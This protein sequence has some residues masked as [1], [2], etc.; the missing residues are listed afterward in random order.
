MKSNPHSRLR[1]AVLARGL[2]SASLAVAGHAAIAQS[3]P[4]RP[5]RLIV[6]QQAGASTDSVARLIALRLGER[7][8]QPFIVENKPGGA[9]RVAMD[10]AIR[11]QPDGQVFA[12]ANA[13]SATFPLVLADYPFIPG[14]DFAPVTMLG[15]APS[16]LAVRSTLP[17]RSVAE[18]VRYARTHGDRIVLGHGG[19]GSNPHISAVALARSIGIRPVELAYK[20]NAPTAVALAAGEVDFAMLDYASVRAFVEK[21]NVRM[22]AVSEPRRFS[23]E[24]NVPT[25]AETGLTSDIEGLTVW[26]MLVAA[27]ATPAP[28]IDAMNRQVREVLALPD[29]RQKLLSMGIEAEPTSVEETTAFFLGQREKLARLTR[30]LSISLRD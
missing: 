11:A 27:P 14:K 28:I 30:Q 2:A 7:L 12:I 21:G 25:G 22:L 15:R 5:V 23:E 20:G 1:R 24:P 29:V 3:W 26:F 13:V 16:F 19:I 4:Q 6:G 17:V 10:S 9:T 8:G 18:F